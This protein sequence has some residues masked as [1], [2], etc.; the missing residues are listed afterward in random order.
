ML[1][2]HPGRED[3]RPEVAAREAWVYIMSVAGS[4][5]HKVGMT[6]RTPSARAAEM[7]WTIGPSKLHVEMAWRCSDARRLE[8]LVHRALVAEGARR[9]GGEWFDQSLPGIVAAVERVAEVH[10]ITLDPGPFRYG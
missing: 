6:S 4:R 5:L 1:Y 2:T 9:I 8:R 10:G 7:G 3:A